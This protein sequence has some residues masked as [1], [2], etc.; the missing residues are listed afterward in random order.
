MAVFIAAPGTGTLPVRIF[1][2][3]HDPVGP[4]APSLSA[5]HAR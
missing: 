2:Y 3:I 4:L 5:G 1:L